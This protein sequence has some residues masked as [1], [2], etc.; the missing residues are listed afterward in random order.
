M[1]AEVADTKTEVY[2]IRNSKSYGWRAVQ[3]KQGEPGAFKTLCFS[4]GR[5]KDKAGALKAL[6]FIRDVFARPLLPPLYERIRE[7]RAKLAVAE[8]N[9]DAARQDRDRLLEQ[10]DTLQNTLHG[11]RGRADRWKARTTDAEG[12]LQEATGSIEARDRSIA[13]L[14][15]KLGKAEAAARRQWFWDLCLM[16]TG[17]GI[18][19]FCLL[20][21]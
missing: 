11:A 3:N 13:V 20:A 9:R 12:R 10:V 17:A 4:T 8:N 16:A 19:W 21:F 15:A 2:R 14:Q 18:L 7:L 1:K 6:G 5:W